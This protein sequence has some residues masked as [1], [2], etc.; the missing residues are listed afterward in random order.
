MAIKDM[1]KS[2]IGKKEPA[3]PA[4]SPDKAT[5]LLT[6]EDFPVYD[7]ADVDLNRYQK[8]PLME[9]ATLGAAFAT[10]PES[11]RTISKTVTTH[12][13]MDRP[14]F[15]GICPKGV[16]GAMIDKGLGFSGNIT[17]IKPQGGTGIVERMRFDLLENGVPATRTMNTV[18]PFDPMTMAVAAA[19]ICV[20][21]KL[22]ALQEKA[23]EILQFLKTEKRSEQ[24][25]NL[26]MLAEI[27]EEY[28]CDCNNEKMCSARFIEVQ[29]I[30]REAHRDILFYQEQIAGKLKNQK[31]F[32]VAQKAQELLEWSL[33][34]GGLSKTAGKLYI[35]HSAL[36]DDNYKELVETSQNLYEQSVAFIRDHREII[37]QV[38]D[39]LLAAKTM[40]GEEISGLIAKKEKAGKTAEKTKGSS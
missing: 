29:A 31:A 11:A 24:R 21:Q 12:I 32:H 4:A 37:E 10:L 33:F 40:T 35:E 26:N 13:A 18:V 27:M 22:D 19:L 14:V 7:A 1:M 28:K 3:A 5:G 30:K 17:G 8:F 25:G 34:R 23:E 20:N 16:H 6:S 9:L 36:N 38:S 39:A 15:A 2:L